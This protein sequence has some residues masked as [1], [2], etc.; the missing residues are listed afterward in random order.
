MENCLITYLSSTTSPEIP[1]SSSPSLLTSPSLP[2]PSILPSSS[3]DDDLS[4]LSW[5]IREVREL[6][7]FQVTDIFEM[8]EL[9]SRAYDIEASFRDLE[10]HLGNNVNYE[11]RDEFCE[12]QADYIPKEKVAKN[13]SNKRK[14]EGDHGGSSSQQQNKDHKVI[15]AHTAGPDNKKDYARNL[16]LCNKC[17][18]H[19]TGPCA[20]KCGNTKEATRSRTLVMTENLNLPSQILNALAEAFKTA[21]VKKKNLLGKNKEFET[22]P[23]RT[24]YIKK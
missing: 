5:I 19:H 13:A 12:N 2:P 18:F 15:R 23:N 21:T 17:K 6:R 16:P 14:W 1:S 10:R 22:R 3:R 8:A 9:R 11:S 24:L 4:C 7:E 20:N